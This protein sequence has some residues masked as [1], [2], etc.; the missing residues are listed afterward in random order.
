M[1]RSEKHSKPQ[2]GH[3][4]A[5]QSLRHHPKNAIIVDLHQRL[6]NRWAKIAKSLPGRTAQAIRQRW[7]GALNEQAD[8]RRESNFSDSDRP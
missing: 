8:R 3:W 7:K 2:L 4:L 1:W 5:V 6:G